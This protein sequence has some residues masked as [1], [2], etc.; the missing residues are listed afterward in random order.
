MSKSVSL[1]NDRMFPRFALYGF[2]KNLRFFDPFIILIFREAGLS[3]LQIGLLYSIRDVATN[4]L[5]IPTGVFADAFGRRKSMVMAFIAYLISFGIFYTCTDFALYALAMILFAFGEAF[6]SGTHK[7]LILEYLTINKMENIKVEYYGR[8]RSV[9]QFGSAINALIPAALVFYTGSY[10]IMFLAAMIP[11]TLDLFNLMGYPRELDGELMQ[12]SK[13][14]VDAQMKATLKD[15][16]GMFTDL[17]A[18][19]AILNSAGFSGLF[20]ATK[21]YLQPIL[22]SFALS[23][24]FLLLLSH[25]QRGALAVGA[26]YF[27]IYLFTSYASRSAATFSRRFSSLGRAINLTFLG[28]AGLLFLS[29]LATWG[30]LV[31]LSI[32]VF[33]GFYILHNL[34]RPMNVAFISDRIS[35]RVMASGLSVES[36]FTTILTAIFAP[37]LGLLADYFGVGIALAVFGAGVLGMYA[38]VRVDETSP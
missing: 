25:K 21:D 4:I 22:E 7:A 36:Q 9:S 15:F 3:F 2:L 26:V 37:L 18:L 8:T 10:R 6:R 32:F 17:K 14:T 35:H 13:E 31:A 16:L 28:G 11:Y 38:F 5:E 20:K 23:L 33:L 24:P 29:G 12:I 19:R 34:R 27:V 1:K 30:N